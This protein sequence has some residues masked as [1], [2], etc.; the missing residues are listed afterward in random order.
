M[1]PASFIFVKRSILEHKYLLSFAAIYYKEPAFKVSGF[2][3]DEESF[4]AFG[5]KG[6]E[7]YYKLPFRKELITSKAFS[8]AG[9]YIIRHSNDYCFISCGPNGQ[10][11]NGGHAHNDKLSFELMLNG[12]DIILDPGTYMYTPYPKIRNKF[13][14]A[15][16]H[17]TIVI[18]GYEQNKIPKK[19]MFS[20][21]ERAKI[22]EASLKEIDNNIVFQGEIHYAGIEHKRIITFGKKSGDFIIQDIVLCAKSLS[23]KVTFH[24]APNLSKENIRIFINKMKNNSTLIELDSFHLEEGKY[25]YSPEYGVKKNA[26]CLF[27]NIIL[28]EKPEPIITRIVKL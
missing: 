11:G 25:Y 15:K 20:L 6:K 10:N 16:Y 7:F 24:L 21:L 1:K 17:N 4:W 22:K 3:F 8:K 9:W 13:R 23:G 2:D 14:S 27:A 18:D 19:D 5:E 28:D 26:E 12:Q